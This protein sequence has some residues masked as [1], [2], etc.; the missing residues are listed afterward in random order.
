MSATVW[1][2]VVE[3][4]PIFTEE[5]SVELP[6]YMMASKFLNWQ[7]PVELPT[8]APHMAQPYATQRNDAARKTLVST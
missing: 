2:E 6:D 4:W 7:V 1:S 3:L 5:S 8:H